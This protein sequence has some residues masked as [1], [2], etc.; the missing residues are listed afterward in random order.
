MASPGYAVEASRLLEDRLSQ[1]RRL[2]LSEAAALPETNGVDTAISGEKASIA[3]FRYLSPF[4]LE[5]SV[6]VV[7]LVARP[8]W[9][10]MAA[11]HIERGLMFSP[12]GNVREATEH[13][14][15]NSGG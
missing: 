6:L 3:T 11:H 13:E 5:G 7:V 10:G 15:Q 9:F 2:T 1:L 12:D 14:L 4:Q 8:R